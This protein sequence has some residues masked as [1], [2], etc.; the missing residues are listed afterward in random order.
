MAVAN[1]YCTFADVKNFFKQA[2]IE[3]IMSE[4]DI[5]AVID[6]FGIEVERIAGMAWRAVA[7]T[8]ELHTLSRN[9][10]TG[11]YFNIYST[12]LKFLHIRSVEEL[13]I[14]DGTDYVDWIADANKTEGRAKDYFFDLENG[15]IYTIGYRWIWRG[16]DVLVSY[17]HGKAIVDT[18][19]W[20]LNLR[21]VA[22]HLMS[23]PNFMKTIPEFK[24][25]K[26]KD[27]FDRNEERIGQ[28]ES[29]MGQTFGVINVGDWV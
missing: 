17:T 8:D 1:G 14:F 7:V 10:S 9:V 6:R 21:Y 22:R 19:A 4:S 26:Q 27:S 28:L 12:K 11:P 15:M 18:D 16:L 20:D 5:E 23:M 24:T 25:G 2:P 29:R 13:K 3:Q